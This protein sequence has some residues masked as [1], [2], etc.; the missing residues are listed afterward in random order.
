MREEGSVAGAQTRPVASVA[1]GRACECWRVLRRVLGRK[2]GHQDDLASVADRS[3][4]SCRMATTRTYTTAVRTPGE[5]RA[6][7]PGIHDHGMTLVHE[8]TGRERNWLHEVS[9]VEHDA[10][11]INYLIDAGYKE[12]R[13]W[14]RGRMQYWVYVKEFPISAVRR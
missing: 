12:H 13:G 11:A 8:L 14:Q 9:V 6:P 1:V 10:Q 5:F 4:D 7:L 3:D 2:N